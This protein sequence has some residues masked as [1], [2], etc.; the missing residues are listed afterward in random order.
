MK[1]LFTAAEVAPFAKVGGLADVAGSLPK[2]LKKL[3]NDI[4][5]ILP[6]YGSINQAKYNLEDVSNSEINIKFGH[7]EFTVSLKQGKIPDSDVTVYFIVNNTY[8]GSHSEIYPD[9][10]H[11]RFEQ[12]RFLVFG[13]STLELMKKIDFKP[14]IIHC[15]DWHTANIPVYLK[16]NYRNCEFYKNTSTVYSIHNLAYQGKFGFEILEFGNIIDNGV[17]GSE[18]LEYFDKINW[19]KGG[20]IYSDQVNTVSPTYAEEIQSPEYGEGLDGLLRSNNYKLTGILNGI[21]YDVWNPKTDPVLPQ[22]YSVVDLSGKNKCKIELQKELGLKQNPVTPLIGL[23]SRLVDQ[24]GLDLIAGIAENIKNM[25]LQLAVLGTGQEKYELLFKDLTTTSDNIKAVIGFNGNLAKKIYAGCDMFL[26]PSRFEPCGLGQLIALKYGT[27]PI[28]R[29][30]GG[31]AD[32]VID[33]NLDE[34]NGNGFVFEDYDSCVLFNAISRALNAYKNEQEWAHITNRAMRFD[35]SWEKS[36]DKY[37]DLY[38]KAL[39]K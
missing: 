21:D 13:L 28:V 15:N 6:L 1:I 23:I 16:T 26:M 18:G 32:T 8:F 34:K 3:G 2:F 27:I 25:D 9:K 37:V 39:N 20:I 30:T 31:L 33:Y 24:K 29:K 36:A 12:E 22:N 38:K 4:R 11:E 17:Y 7:R 14:D 19:M 5:V 35:F 10:A